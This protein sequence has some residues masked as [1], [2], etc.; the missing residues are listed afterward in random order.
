M[1]KSMHNDDAETDSHETNNQLSY[2]LSSTGKMIAISRRITYLIQ[3]YFQPF[4][5]RS[6]L[7]PHLTTARHG[8]F[9][10]YSR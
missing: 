2:I 7:V 5:T 3:L 9:R 10:Y 1:K 8:H 4:K 6:G